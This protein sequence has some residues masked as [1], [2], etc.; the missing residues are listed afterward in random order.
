M[1]TV[2]IVG[3]IMGGY[4]LKRR[5]DRFPALARNHARMVRSWL[6]LKAQRQS[7]ARASPMVYYRANLE[8]RYLLAARYPWFHVDPDQPPPSP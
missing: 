1:V 6:G 4:H 8:A 5:N 2:A 3:L 7:A